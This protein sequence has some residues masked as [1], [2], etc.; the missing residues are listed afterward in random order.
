MD[1]R[2]DELVYAYPD[3]YDPDIQTK[4]TAKWEF[5]ELAPEL[6]VKPTR[7][8]LYLHQELVKRFM[9]VYDRLLLYHRAG[10]GK[11]GAAFGAAEQFKVALGATVDYIRDYILPR[12]TYIKRVIVLTRGATLINEL[13]SQ[14]VCRVNPEN[15]ITHTVLTA[16][17]PITQIK[18]LNNIIRQFYDIYTYGGFANLIR[19][20]NDEQLK[21]FYSNHLFIV[22][23]VQNLNLTDVVEAEI[24][25]QRA[26]RD[27]EATYRSLHRLF[28]VADRIK[29]MLLSAT[30]IIDKATEIVSVMNLLLPLDRQMDPRLLDNPSLSTL[31][32]Y[33]R[34]LVSYVREINPNVTIVFEGKPL[35]EFGYVGYQSVVWPSVMSEHQASWYPLETAT[36]FRM[37]E[38]QAA[39]FVYPNGSYGDGEDAFRRYIRYVQ[40]DIYEP[41]DELRPFLNDTYLGLLSAKFL[42]IIRLC[43]DKPGLCFVSS[44][45]KYAGAILLSV[46]FRAFGFEQYLSEEAP[47]VAKTE[48]DYRLTICRGTNENLVVKPDYPQRLRFALFTPETP[49]SRQRSILQLFNSYEN[50]HGQYI[51]VLI[52]SP[53]LGTG[54]NLLNVLNVHIVDPS[55]DES[56]TYQAF[57][58]ALRGTTSHISLVNESTSPVVVHIYRHASVSP[59]RDIV[60][61]HMYAV[62][63]NK[64]RINSQVLRI[65][66]QCAIDGYVHRQRNIRPNDVEGTPECDYQSCVY[67]LSR[68]FPTAFDFSSYDVLYSHDLIKDIIDGI[69]WVM[70]EQTRLSLDD[71]IRLVGRR[72]NRLYE[73]KY[74]LRALEFIISQKLPLINRYGLTSYLYE[75]NNVYYLLND[76]PIT[77]YKPTIADTYYNHNFFTVERTSLSDY[78]AKVVHNRLGLDQ[79][80]DKVNHGQLTKD[81]LE[82]VLHDYTPYTKATL[83]EEAIVHKYV[84]ST[85][86]DQSS[87]TSTSVDNGNVDL[88]TDYVVSIYWFYIYAFYEPKKEIENYR[89]RGLKSPT[90]ITRLR[91]SE[92]EQTFYHPD[93]SNPVVYVHTIYNQTEERVGY[94]VAARTTKAEG[95]IRLYKD[96]IWRDANEYE[97]Y[98]YNRLIQIEIN[99]RILPYETNDIY[100]IYFQ[101]KDR[102]FRIR[103]KTTE[104]EAT[105]DI[106]RIN[107]GRECTTWRKAELVLLMRK[108][109]VP[110]PS[111]PLASK[112]VMIRFVLS[113]GISPQTLTNAT[114][115]DLRYYYRWLDV[116][117]SREAMCKAL[118]DHMAATGRLLV[119]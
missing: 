40:P 111:T 7:G 21:S 55:W 57:S 44:N 107:R 30:P 56:V 24:V 97:T 26:L 48:R 98:V 94:A 104:K 89:L 83:V 2:L 93:M 38:R 67:E 91:K 45:F 20:Y 77:G 65:M 42:N 39:N 51:K 22:D 41:N 11:T 16:P 15:Y 80:R 75:D 60:D 58:R 96:G 19:N 86:V 66:K 116:N 90:R 33:F 71:L 114:D 105:R 3:Q 110:E 79:L 4:I 61:L 74:Y 103:D 95:R 63:E 118:M 35:S 70:A 119:I 68:P 27:K 50:R 101:T 115:E 10:T 46:C 76:Y 8:N 62:S 28:H 49:I 108:V 69:R 9:L 32:P 102:R 72:L 5:Y 106:R 113:Q 47:L 87:P 23:E 59:Q 92:L 81:A 25:E 82:D 85:S 73:R 18:R 13:K 6:N 1:I 109:G 117:R 37:N 99:N 31:E 64:D 112:D 43:R 52:G 100:G 84:K 54:V 78:V 17:D 29:V 88:F 14:L 12:R 36:T 53:I 34:G